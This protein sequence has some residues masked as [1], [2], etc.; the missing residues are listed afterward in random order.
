MEALASLRELYGY[1]P[2]SCKAP[3]P[4]LENADA[5]DRACPMLDRLI[6]T[7]PNLPYDMKIVIQEVGGCGSAASSS[8][9]NALV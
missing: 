1:L 8:A 9:Q 3:L 4:V 7:D 5:R 6:P 2:L